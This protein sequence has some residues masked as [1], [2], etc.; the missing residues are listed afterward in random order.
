[1]FQVFTDASGLKGIGGYYDNQIFASRVPS[2]HEDKHINWKEMFAVLHALILWHK[3]WAY[4]SVDVACDNAAIVG[5][6]NKRSILGPAI[7]PLRMILLISAIFD[8][9]IKAHWVS[10]KEN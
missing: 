7:R 6:I 4:G 1:S 10:M 8:I 3:E 9:D 5:G 2:R